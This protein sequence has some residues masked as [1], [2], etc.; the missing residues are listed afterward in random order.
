MKAITSRAKAL[1]LVGQALFLART[2]RDLAAA[3]WKDVG[4][5]ARLVR[6]WAERRYLAV[7]WR[8][9]A[10]AVGALAYFVNPFDAIPDMLLGIGYLDDASVLAMVAASLHSDLER[11]ADWEQHED[12]VAVDEDG[13]SVAH[14]REAN[15]FGRIE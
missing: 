5:L 12:A 7:P 6:A 11:F 13:G 15:E 3:A 10:L 9:I 14:A 2:R 1:R 4:R 8:S